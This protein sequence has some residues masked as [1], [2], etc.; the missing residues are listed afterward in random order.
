MEGGGLLHL[1]LQPPPG[2]FA[3][4]FQMALPQ[5]PPGVFCSA[6][7]GSAWPTEQPEAWGGGN[8]DNRKGFWVVLGRFLRK[9]LQNHPFSSGFIRGFE[10]VDS[11]SQNIVLPMVYWCLEDFWVPQ[12]AAAGQDMQSKNPRGGFCGGTF[13]LDRAR[14]AER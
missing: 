9:C 5:N 7:L 6:G 8:I 4:G 10:G 1:G 11:E 2:G 12:R 13:L 3:C 14:A